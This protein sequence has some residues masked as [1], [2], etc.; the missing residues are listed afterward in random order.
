MHAGYIRPIL[1]R[2][3]AGECPIVRVMGADPRVGT[4]TGPLKYEIVPVVEWSKLDLYLN[5]F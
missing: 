2:L 3:G 4:Y 1:A 5:I